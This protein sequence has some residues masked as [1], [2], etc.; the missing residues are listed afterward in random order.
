MKFS[1]SRCLKRKKAAEMG[2]K[3]RFLGREINFFFYK[4]SISV[5]QIT[6]KTNN[7]PTITDSNCA[8]T[9]KLLSVAKLR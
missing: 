7:L 5:T 1:K 6:Q 4:K 9:R 2:K 3:T 8:V